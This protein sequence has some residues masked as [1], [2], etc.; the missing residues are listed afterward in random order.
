MKRTSIHRTANTGLAVM[1]AA[2]AL[3]AGCAGGG[4][5]A[6]SGDNSKGEGKRGSI[7][8]SLYD[9]GN[10][11]V[12]EGT[13]DNNRWTKWLNEQGPV[14][15]KF[16]PIPRAESK[17]KFNVLFASAGAPDLVFDYDSGLMNDLYVQKQLL[18]LDDL[19]QNNSTEYKKLADQYPIL[20]EMGR[21]PDGKI[22]QFGRLL[23]M[24][25]NDLLFIRKDWLKKLNLEVPKTTEELYAVAKAFREQ[26]PDGNGVKDTYAINLSYTAEN[27]VNAMFQN[28]GVFSKDGKLEKTWEQAREA[29]AFKKRL[30][31]EGL[32]DKDFLT[33]K[34]G[35]KAKQDWINGKL[36]MYA[37]SSG[38]DQVA[39]F[40]TYQSLK[41]NVPDAEVIPIELP[42][43]PY[44]Q[45]NPNPK[46]PVQLTAA[47]NA[48]TKDPKAAMKYVDF[49]V[50]KPT[51]NTLKNGL[52]GQHYKTDKD[53]CA[54]PIDKEKNKKE[55]VM[56]NDI[57]MLS[58]MA[59]MGKCEKYEIKLSPEIPQEK[60]FLTM[61]ETADKIYLN[62]NLPFATEY[63]STILP[64]LSADLV[65]IN[66]NTDTINDLWKKAIVSGD[67]YT[68]EQAMVEAKSLWEKSGGKQIDDF[69]NK[70][71]QENKD[72]PM[73]NNDFIK[74]KFD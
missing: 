44:G 6:K 71:Y 2:G 14:D 24:K 37:Q 19:I 50:S 20:K 16:V 15:V 47:I 61:I 53:G 23:G 41:K 30:F 46:F 1:L 39:T 31:S 38:A 27:V 17:Q 69:Y 11:P 74:L 66:K 58:S 73:R 55:M 62:P 21:K 52:E 4:D 68:P 34:N 36:G 42:K 28:T 64:S 49:L 70:W 43:G 3:L 45:F 40:A 65:V 32:V 60:E 13:V 59:L 56:T 48:N 9:R 25:T 10:V 72:K 5:A 29:T 7:S 54:Q 57:A 51:M 18:P 8:S 67:K 33:D 22:Y 26:D 63:D 35:E 12:E